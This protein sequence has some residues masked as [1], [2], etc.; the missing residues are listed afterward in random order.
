MFRLVLPPSRSC[1]PF[2][3]PAWRTGL[4][5]I[6]TGVPEKYKCI[7]VV[8]RVVALRLAKQFCRALRLFGHVR[9]SPGAH[10]GCTWAT[11][12]SVPADKV[13]HL[14]STVPGAEYSLACLRDP[15]AGSYRAGG[16]GVFYAL[17]CATALGCAHSLRG[18]RRSGW[19]EI[20]EGGEAERVRWRSAP[21]HQALELLQVIASGQRNLNPKVVD[22]SG[23]AGL[24]TGQRVVPPEEAC[25][26][27][28]VRLQALRALQSP[29][30]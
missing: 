23:A 8:R 22:T 20:C 13:C 15:A 19:F 27:A 2:P 25:R 14:T 1:S 12:E 24:G 3:P 18:G 16:R 5:S 11:R 21:S 7:I 26:L 9:E 29:D 17:H 10:E 6:T 28:P 30:G 4:T